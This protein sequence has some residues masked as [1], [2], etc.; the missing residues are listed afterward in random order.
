M[1]RAARKRNKTK[2]AADRH[3]GYAHLHNAVDDHAHHH[4]FNV[5]ALR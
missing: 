3:P 2:T 1:D 5:P 4:H